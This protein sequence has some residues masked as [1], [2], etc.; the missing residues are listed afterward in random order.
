VGKQ[1]EAP[2]EKTSKLKGD[3][4]ELEE[5]AKVMKKIEKS[6]TSWRRCNASIM[7][8]TLQAVC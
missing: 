7:A 5:K 8:R 3:F 4:R 6:L 1:M 2:M